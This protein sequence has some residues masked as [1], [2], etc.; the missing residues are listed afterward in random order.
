MA[1]LKSGHPE[2]VFLY[3][4]TCSIHVCI[5]GPV[6]KESH[7]LYSRPSG[8]NGEQMCADRQA[9][10]AGYVGSVRVGVFFS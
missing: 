5:V 6:L 8:S 9:S 3:V 1:L 7:R 2:P 4:C 10:G